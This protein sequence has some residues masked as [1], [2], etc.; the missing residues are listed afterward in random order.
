MIEEFNYATI[1]VDCEAIADR[2]I[3]CYVRFMI[4]KLKT[5]KKY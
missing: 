3:N 4:R 5:L 1:D 2:I